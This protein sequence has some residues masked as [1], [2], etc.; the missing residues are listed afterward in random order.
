MKHSG[1]L[2][3]GS[4]DN[5]SQDDNHAPPEQD[6]AALCYLC[7][8]LADMLRQVRPCYPQERSPTPS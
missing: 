1:E 2:I 7:E 3:I 5:G 8:L 6:F 4:P